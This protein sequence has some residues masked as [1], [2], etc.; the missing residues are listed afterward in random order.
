MKATMKPEK[1]SS[2]FSFDIVIANVSVEFVN[3]KHHHPRLAFG[4][5]FG[6]TSLEPVLGLPD[7]HGVLKLGPADSRS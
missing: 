6:P 3:F 5:S 1:A 7:F 4:M 2:D